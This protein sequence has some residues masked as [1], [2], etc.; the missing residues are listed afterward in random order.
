MYR[1]WPQYAKFALPKE[2]RMTEYAGPSLLMSRGWLRTAHPIM[3]R[4]SVTTPVTAAAAAT[5]G[6]ANRVRAPGP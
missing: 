4:G 1:V 6:P 5:R 2:V 3:L